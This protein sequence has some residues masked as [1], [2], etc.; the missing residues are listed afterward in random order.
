MISSC[1]VNQVIT[2]P[3]KIF[4]CNLIKIKK[5]SCWPK[6]SSSVL[7][8]EIVW[9]RNSKMTTWSPVG[10]EIYVLDCNF[11]YDHNFY[12]HVMI[13]F[14][15][16]NKT[17]RGLGGL[18]IIGLY[19]VSYIFSKFF[20]VRLTSNTNISL[21]MAKYCSW[22]SSCTT[23]RWVTKK[24]QLNLVSTWVASRD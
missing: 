8:Y 23:S 14:L 19:R 9:Q 13:I 6:S 24:C 12:Y 20:S 4:V 17:A 16:E 21:H 5:R 3:G 2:Q 22:I 7:P 10:W 15:L 18:M 11:Y 1:L